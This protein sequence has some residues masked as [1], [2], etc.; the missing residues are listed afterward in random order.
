MSSTS[1][2]ARARSL[3]L[4]LVALLAASSLARGQDNVVQDLPP[5]YSLQAELDWFTPDERATDRRW[6]ERVFERYTEELSAGL[7]GQVLKLLAEEF[8]AAPW[9]SHTAVQARFQ[10]QLDRVAFAFVEAQAK[11]ALEGK[12]ADRTERE[13]LIAELDESRVGVQSLLPEAVRIDPASTTMILVYFADTPDR[14]DTYRFTEDDQHELLL[15]PELMRDLRLRGEAVRVVLQDFV[16]PVQKRAYDQILRADRQW[17]NLLEKGYSQYPWESLFNGW[18]LDFDAFH[19]PS[20]QWI[21]LHPTVGFEAS[22]VSLDEITAE[23]VVN[24][25]V[26][27]YLHYYGDDYQHYLG[28]ALTATLRDDLGPGLGVVAHW[29][30]GFSLGVAWHD[31]DGDGDQFDDDPFVYFSVD[32]FKFVQGERP[33]F[34]AARDQLQGMLDSR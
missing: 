13:K 4:G 32:L 33:K 3:F 34:Q 7:H 28:G 31:V 23:E 26:L 15:P 21:L 19:P 8:R 24:V 17:T 2:A 27:G 16:E 5:Q 20:H 22:T 25:E 1:F 9:P 10:S 6:H 29:E 30:K 18:V 12:L 14:F 11:R